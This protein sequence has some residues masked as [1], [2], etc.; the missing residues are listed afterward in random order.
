MAHQR[1]IRSTY[2]R[3]GATTVIPECSE[4]L[5]VVGL[6][7]EAFGGLGLLG[8]DWSYL[9]AKAKLLITISLSMRKLSSF[10]SPL[11]FLADSVYVVSTKR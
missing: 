4:W 6:I 8:E 3:I 9:T 5:L 1:G 2:H 7:A 10:A 11:L